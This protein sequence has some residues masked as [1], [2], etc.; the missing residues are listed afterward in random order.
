[1]IRLTKYI[2]TFALAVFMSNPALAAINSSDD[3]EGYPLGPDA[4]P[5]GNWQVFAAVY[6]GFP[7]CDP[8]VYQYGTFPAPNSS[9]A[10]SNI[11]LGNSGQALNVFS[12]YNNGDHGIGRC[13]ETSIFKEVASFNAADAG[14]YD[15]SFDTQVPATPLGA[16]VRVFGFVKLL[17]PLNGFQADIFKTVE[18]VSG[19]SKKITVT[20][21]NTA[22]GKVLQWG[23]STVASNYLPSGR[24]YDNVTFAIS[25]APPTMTRVE[26]VPIPAWAL[27]LMAGLLTYLGLTRLRA[28]R[29]T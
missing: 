14:T 10:F 12:D 9:S 8:W 16:G 18:T 1:M 4:N 15:F 2:V 22:D 6:E 3:F 17:D 7:T 13:I 27:L 5:I 25:T 23:F 21:D 19:G 20:L 28:S 26:G 11:T 29:Q 24:F